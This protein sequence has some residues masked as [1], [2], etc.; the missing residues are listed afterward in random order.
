M[1]T[2]IQ[3]HGLV[4]STTLAVVFRSLKCLD[5][6]FVSSVS[7]FFS[8]FVTP[9]EGYKLILMTSKGLCGTHIADV[10]RCVMIRYREKIL[11]N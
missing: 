10:E 8:R 6:A 11:I 3:F 1:A 2:W 7:Y 5:S 4:D 9:S